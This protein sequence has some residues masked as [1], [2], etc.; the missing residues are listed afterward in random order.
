MGKTFA[1]PRC[2]ILGC[3][4]K[5]RCSSALRR[6][7]GS[8]S[9]LCLPQGLPIRQSADRRNPNPSA[10]FH[11][12]FQVSRL[13]SHS[14]SSSSS[15]HEHLQ[16]STLTSTISVHSNHT[17]ASVWITRRRCIVCVILVTA[18][19]S[20]LPTPRVFTPRDCLDDRADRR[21][22]PLGERLCRETWITIVVVSYIEGRKAARHLGP[23]RP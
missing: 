3:G 16:A 2:R 17:P 18:A 21:F 7:I 1:I 10:A 12:P 22:R 20:P 5:L 13:S 14:S 19:P 8:A 9:G 11:K 4:P 23:K 6:G 15:F